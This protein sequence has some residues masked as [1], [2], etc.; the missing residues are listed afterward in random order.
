MILRTALD[1]NSTKLGQH[2]G[3][4]AESEPTHWKRSEET[5]QVVVIIKYLCAYVSSISAC[6]FVKVSI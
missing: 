2:F 3:E 5:I 6:V 4:S 1:D